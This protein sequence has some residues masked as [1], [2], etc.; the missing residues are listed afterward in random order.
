MIITDTLLMS[1]DISNGSSMQI[2]LVPIFMMTI[3]GFISVMFH[4][5]LTSG[6]VMC[7]LSTTETLTSGDVMC[8]INDGNSNVG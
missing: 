5:T 7:L 6:D 2:L 1:F 3:F 4:E 8:L